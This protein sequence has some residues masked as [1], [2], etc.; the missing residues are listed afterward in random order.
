[1]L[2]SQF[3]PIK[4]N[5]SSSFHLF[6]HIIIFDSINFDRKFTISV[7]LYKEEEEENS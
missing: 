2:K 4:L 3:S 6:S 7:M 5:H 1:M